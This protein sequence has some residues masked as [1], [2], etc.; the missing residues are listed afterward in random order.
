VLRPPLPLGLWLNALLLFSETEYS[1]GSG[2]ILISLGSFLPS[3]SHG[4]IVKNRRGHGQYY[5]VEDSA[6]TPY[7]CQL[8]DRT[9]YI[10]HIFLASSV[11]IA[12]KLV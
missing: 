12:K 3:T 7:F 2:K 4:L 6:G 10:P 8:V 1:V 5:T 9:D 11:I